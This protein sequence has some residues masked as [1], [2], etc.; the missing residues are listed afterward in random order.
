MA[1]CIVIA[2]MNQIGFAGWPA[3]LLVAVAAGTLGFWSTIKKIDERDI[4]AG[5][6]FGYFCIFM[7]LLRWHGLLGGGVAPVAAATWFIPMSR[8]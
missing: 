8:G 5:F 4:V 2:I 1:T 6:F 7:T 3:G